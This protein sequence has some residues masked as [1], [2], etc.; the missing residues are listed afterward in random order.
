MYSML[1]VDDEPSILYGLKDII[2]WEEYGVEIAGL[3][4][5]GMEALK[6]IDSKKINIL[7]TDIRMPEIDG[8]ELIGHIRRRNPEIRVIILSG[9]DDFNYVKE[10]IKLGVENYL[11]KPLNKNELSS[12][13]LNTVEK[14]ESES[15]RKIYTGKNKDV[16]K[17]NLLYRWVSNNISRRELVERASLIDIDLDYRQFAVATVDIL[18]APGLIDR[19]LASHAVINIC[20]EIAS[21][22]INTMIYQDLNNNIILLF[23]GNDLMER[24]TIILELLQK[25]TAK[26]NTLLKINVFTTLGTI[27]NDCQSVYKSYFSSKDL[28]D[29]SLIYAANSILDYYAVKEAAVSRQK[30]IDINFRLFGEHLIRKRKDK[31][32]LFIEDLFRQVLSINGLTP[33]DIQNI[34]IEILFNISSVCKKAAGNKSI[35]DEL[36]ILFSDVTGIKTSRELIDWVKIIIGKAIDYLDLRE[37]NRNPLIDQIIKYIHSNYR[38]AISL[39]AL[40]SMFNVNTS[41]L[42]QLFK[43]ETGELFTNY[44]N[45]V[46]IEK[47]KKLLTETNLKV[48]D[49]SSKVGYTNQSLFF[50]TFKKQT[51]VSPEEFREIALRHPNNQL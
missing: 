32:F 46:R 18:D 31:A 16:F 36:G 48:Y 23:S 26:I 41:Y 7:L 25:Y 51:D 11:L 33:K 1:I 13:L 27:E 47:A 24:K 20:N 4:G 12:T 10:A 50:R 17:Q 3:A 45:N 2:D 49:I 38:E 19:N 40:S 35:P 29:F 39:K 8:I 5:N 15:Y 21:E 34:S 37:K 9:Y 6:I 30:E 28:Q 42:G 44:L 22:E 14:I 43:T